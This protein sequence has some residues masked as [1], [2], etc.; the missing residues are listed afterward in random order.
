MS[1]MINL[2]AGLIDTVPILMPLSFAFYGIFEH[3]DVYFGALQ[4]KTLCVHLCL[5][6]VVKLCNPFK[7]DKGG[8]GNI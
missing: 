3:L 5:V 8:F 4:N 2:R 1:T 6:R 7:G